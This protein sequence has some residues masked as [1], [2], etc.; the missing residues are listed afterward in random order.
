MASFSVGPMLLLPPAPDR[1]DLG[2]KLADLLG[3][4]SA[5]LLGH[6]YCGSE[7]LRHSPHSSSKSKLLNLSVL[8]FSETVLIVRS[9]APSGI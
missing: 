2:Q 5:I 9:P 1:L 7:F 8:Q 3:Y 6:G 4:V